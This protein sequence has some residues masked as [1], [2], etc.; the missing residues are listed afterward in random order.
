MGKLR[1][2]LTTK[3]I[4]ILFNPEHGIILWSIATDLCIGLMPAI[5]PKTAIGMVKF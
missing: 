3:L 1:D 5:R 2:I 4:S